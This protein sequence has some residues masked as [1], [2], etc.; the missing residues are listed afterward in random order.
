MSTVLGNYS[1]MLCPVMDLVIGD[2]LLAALR[3]P[4]FF[5]KVFVVILGI[6]RRQTLRKE[7]VIRRTTKLVLGACHNEQS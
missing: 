2:G 4:P 5:C 6:G 7:P 1:Q 3:Q